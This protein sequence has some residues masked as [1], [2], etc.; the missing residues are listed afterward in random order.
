MSGTEVLVVPSTGKRLKPDAQWVGTRGK[1]KGKKVIM[2]QGV[3][4]SGK[5]IDEKRKLYD[6]MYGKGRYVFIKKTAK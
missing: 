3:T 5:S 4:Q 6:Q 2:E 1:Y